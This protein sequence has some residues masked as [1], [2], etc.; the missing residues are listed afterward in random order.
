MSTA[1]AESSR[2]IRDWKWSQTEKTVAHKAFDTALERE[3]VEVIRQTKERASRITCAAQAWELETWLAERRVEIDRSFDFRYSVLPFVFAG[4]L[5]DRRIS[6]VEL[7][8]LA[9]E[10]LVAIR[11]LAAL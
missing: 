1:H 5:R 3:L 6:E 8:G 11:K 2:S 9:E 4:L 7:N 10:K